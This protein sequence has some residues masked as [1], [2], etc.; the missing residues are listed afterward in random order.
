[1]GRASDAGRIRHARA[2]SSGT[3]R[4]SSTTWR[5]R[6][7]TAGQRPACLST[8]ELAEE[9][10][11]ACPRRH[12]STRPGS[13]AR[14]WRCARASA[15][16]ASSGWNMARVHR[17]TATCR[18]WMSCCSALMGRP[19]SRPGRFRVPLRLL[20]AGRLLPEA[21]RPLPTTTTGVP[22]LPYYYLSEAW[23]AE[24]GGAL[25]L[26]LAGPDRAGRCEAPA[27]WCCSSL[28]SCPEIAGNPR[29]SVADWLVQAARPWF[30]GGR[31]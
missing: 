26:Y 7:V 1:M 29:T 14:A 22:S 9:C 19:L 25:R 5:T 20:P 30:P 27:P 21:P 18:P 8:H 10:R 24:H 12:P 17:A 28:P 6:L 31:H 13:V 4:R 15:A 23:Q 3:C 16:A 2:T 11:K